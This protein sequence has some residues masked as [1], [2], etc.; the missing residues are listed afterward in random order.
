VPRGG[1]PGNPAWEKGKSQNPYGRPRGPGTVRVQKRIQVALLEFAKL[2]ADTYDFPGHDPR[3][4]GTYQ[5]LLDIAKDPKASAAIKVA[6]LAAASKVEPRYLHNP[7]ELPAFQSIQEAEAFKLQLSR[8]ELKNDYDR[9]SVNRAFTR[10]DNW[11]MD[12]RQDQASARA[13]AELE[14][15]RLAADVSD[16]PQVI[17]IEGGLPELPGT[18]VTMPHQL[19]GNASDGLLPKQSV[20]I[21]HSPDPQ[22]HPPEET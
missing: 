3:F 10:I 22:T 15:K 6:A 20:V 18:N 16:Q 8:Q 4:P 19:N 14:L 2:M 17:K 13:E 9:D 7:I 21:E 12:Q 5:L 11:I 1:G